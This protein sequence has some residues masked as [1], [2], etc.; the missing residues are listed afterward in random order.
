MLRQVVYTITAVLYRVNLDGLLALGLIKKDAMEQRRRGTAPHISNLGI[1][2]ELRFHGPATFP[3]EDS[4]AAH[5]TGGALGPKACV[6]ALKIKI[7]CRESKPQFICRPDSSRTTV[8]TCLP[9]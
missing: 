4:P 9:L 7:S 1:G 2:G 3:R 8:P 6:D 5:W